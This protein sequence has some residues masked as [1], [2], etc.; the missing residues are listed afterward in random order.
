[1]MRVV[2][3]IPVTLYLVTV[4]EGFLTCP[5]EEHMV[6]FP[7]DTTAV[8]PCLFRPSLRF[9]DRL[10]RVSWQK[11]HEV[12]DLVVHFQNGNDTG[13][14]QNELFKGRTTMSKNWFVEGNATLKLEHV[15]KKDAGKYTC[16]VTVYP[17]RPGLQCKCCVVVLDIS[18]QQNMKMTIS[19]EIETHQARQHFSS[20]QQSNFGNDHSHA[21]WE[22]VL[23]ACLFLLVVVLFIFLPYFLFSRQHSGPY[24]IL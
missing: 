22:R 14:K 6:S 24:R 2:V 17:I 11:E 7:R 18:D 23:A 15:R 4:L 13:D 8:L 9:S 3:V 12:E 19:P 16:W 21:V 10:L 1:M 20:L 5:E